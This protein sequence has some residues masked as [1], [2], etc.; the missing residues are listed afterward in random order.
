M[1]M[2]KKAYCMLSIQVTGFVLGAF[3]I[4][5]HQPENGFLFM[6][7]FTG[8]SWIYYILKKEVKPDEQ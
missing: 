7:L 3:A 6:N 5:M 2:N 4:L 8:F 1:E